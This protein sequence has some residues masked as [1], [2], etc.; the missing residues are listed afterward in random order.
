[1]HEI[2]KKYLR[3]LNPGMGTENVG[4]L[5]YNLIQIIRP[6]NVLEVGLGYSTALIAEG[7]FKSKTNFEKES[8]FPG[9]SSKSI[10]FSTEP[11]S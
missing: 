4:P 9:Q 3:L 8:R 7:L 6:T 1:M 5:K 11:S 2:E 10:L